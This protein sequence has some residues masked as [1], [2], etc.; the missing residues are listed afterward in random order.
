MNKNK[1]GRGYVIRFFDE[2]R[3]T[4]VYLCENTRREYTLHLTDAKLFYTHKEAIDELVARKKAVK[5]QY[6]KGYLYI[7]KVFY[8]EQERKLWR[9]GGSDIRPTKLTKPD[10]HDFLNAI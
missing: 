10:R 2:S 4:A 1:A 9:G 3:D 7:S 6:K 8:K 5:K